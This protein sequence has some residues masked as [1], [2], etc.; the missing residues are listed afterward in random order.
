V[1]PILG[2]IASGITSSKIVTTS[3]DSIATSTPS[4]GT[5]SITF[6]SIPQ[7]YKSL[8]VR[9]IVRDTSTGG[10]D[11]IPVDIRPN[12][13]SGSNYAIHSLRGDGATVTADGYTAQPQGLPWAAAIRS[14][15]S[16]TTT[17]GVMI[18]DII[19]YTSTSKY[20]TLRMVSG[21]DVNGTGGVVSLDSAL[22][23]STSAITSLTI[24]A[25]YTAFAS[26]TTFA[27]YGIK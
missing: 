7:T 11:A 25:D 22:W 27:L 12:N 13:D 16:N 18:L 6:S 10:Y 23:L 21:G 5:T 26:G 19:D 20:K 8:Q 3:F 1:S 24:K 2:I 17:Y 14:G 4:N 9:S 15:S